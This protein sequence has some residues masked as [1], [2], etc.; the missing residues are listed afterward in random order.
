MVGTRP[1]Y[2]FWVAHQ[3]EVS[4]TKEVVYAQNPVLTHEI[5]L[6]IIFRSDLI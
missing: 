5:G 2:I 4:D 1:L 6:K 3:A